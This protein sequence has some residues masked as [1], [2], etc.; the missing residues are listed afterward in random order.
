MGERVYLDRVVH[1]RVPQRLY[2]ALEQEA[3]RQRLRPADVARAA[4]GVWVAQG[5]AECEGHK[6]TSKEGE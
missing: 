1:I 2:D 4:L 5:Q 6:Q 3:Q